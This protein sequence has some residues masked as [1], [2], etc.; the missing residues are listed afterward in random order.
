MGA[1]STSLMVPMEGEERR[2]EGMVVGVMSAGGDEMGRGGEEEHL[3]GGNSCTP[4]ETVWPDE[5][6]H[7]AG[8]I[9][10]A[11]SRRAASRWLRVHS[12]TNATED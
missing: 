6:V 7:E 1:S 5:A 10:T 8:E 9:F 4:G 11:C 12:L 3:S 2:L